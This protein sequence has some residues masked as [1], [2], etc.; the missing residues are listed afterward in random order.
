MMTTYSNLK[1]FLFCKTRVMNCD[2]KTGFWKLWHGAIEEDV[3]AINIAFRKEISCRK[4]RYQRLMKD[5]DKTSLCHLIPY[6]MQQLRTMI[7]GTIFGQI[8]ATWREGQVYRK[9]LNM[10]YT[11]NYGVPKK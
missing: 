1:T 5:I 2:Y 3:E 7:D 11:W 10:A 8:T 9:I 4:E 6:W